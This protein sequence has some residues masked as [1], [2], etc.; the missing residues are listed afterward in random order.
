MVWDGAGSVFGVG[1][2]VAKLAADGSTPAGTAS[3]YVSDALV[4]LEFEPL[5]DQPD[6]V[7]RKNAAGRACVLYQAPATLKR[8]TIT[9]LEVCSPD[10]ELEEILA[11]G[12][13]LTQSTNTV[14]LAWPAVGVDAQPNG[15]SLEVWSRAIDANGAPASTNPYFRWVMPRLYLRRGAGTI[16]EGPFGPVYS[17]HGIQNSNWGNGPANDWTFASNRVLQWARESAGPPV[18]S[19]GSIAIPTQTP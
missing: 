6:E 4:K 15:L 9:S 8:L 18:N 14:G 7:V 19:G 5:Y 3:M 10:P 16:E 17:G 2:R 12:T 11:G 13:I 1:M